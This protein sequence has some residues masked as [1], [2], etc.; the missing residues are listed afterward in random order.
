M[1]KV[2]LMR[3]DCLELMKDIPDNSVDVVISDI[4]YGIDFSS[5]DVLHKNKN[6]S[7]LGQSPA[8]IKE[9]TLFKSR[10]KPKNGWSEADKQRPKEFQDFCEGWL[11]EI[12]RVTKECSPIII[13][14]G[15]QY[16]HRFTIAAENC[17]F[18]F[19]D[20]LTWDKKQ[21][22]FRAQ[23]INRVLE[24]RN[25][26]LMDGE[27]RLGNLSPQSEP[28]V[29]MFKPYGIGKTITDCFI[30]NKLGCIETSEQKNNILEV[31]SKIKERSHETEK[32]IEIMEKL[33]KMFSVEGHTVLDM[34]MGSGTTGVACINTG[35]N[36]I[37]I[38][39]DENYFN[40]ADT[41]INRTNQENNID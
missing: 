4:P 33:V 21:A 20:S 12:Y 31:S 30:E 28:I 2:K 13:F 35:R 9:G 39:M 24:R 36:F 5:W 16:Q 29:W 17:G 26:E 8:Q 19:K 14:T 18:I 3:G 27:Y 23:N 40:I 11:K 34:F 10:G 15:R 32:P 22:P 6:S 7:L 38:E 37:G 1:I 25:L 41:R